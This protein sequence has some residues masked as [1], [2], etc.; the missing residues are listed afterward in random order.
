VSF[1]VDTNVLLELVA[2]QPHPAVL[3]W[4]DAADEG[5]LF[6]SVLSVGELQRGV[7]KLPDSRRRRRLAEWLTSDLLVRFD[8][9]LLPIDGPVALAWGSLV[10]EV[11]AAGRPMPAVDSLLAATARTHNLTLVTRNTADFEPADIELLDPWEYDDA[12]PS[13]E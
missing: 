11:E 9:R 4:V 3:A 1:L 6:I 12:R 10:E 8:R 7:A 2:A 13:L 5:S